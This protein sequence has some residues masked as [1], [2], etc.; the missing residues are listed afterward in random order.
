MITF[1]TTHHLFSYSD[2]VKC[3]MTDG[4]TD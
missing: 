4:R 1:G 3:V 2:A